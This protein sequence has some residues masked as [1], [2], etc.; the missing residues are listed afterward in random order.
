MK[1]KAAKKSVKKTTAQK[2]R[3]PAAQVKKSP[4]K[5]LMAPSILSADFSKL[6]AEVKEVEKAGAEWIHVD[7]MDGHFVPNLTLGPVIVKALRPRTRLVL[8]CHLMVK[9][10]ENWI[11]PF[12]TAGAD[13]ITIH[14]EACSDL[15]RA[16]GK[17][18]HLGK[19]AGV[20]INPATPLEVIESVLDQ[21][22]LVLIM[23]VNP[24]FGGQG[25]MESVL[26]KLTRLRKIKMDL[27]LR[28]PSNGAFLIEID[29]GISASNAEQVVRSG[30]DVLVAGSAI[31]GQKNR[32]K[33]LREIRSAGLL[34]TK[35]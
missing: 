20:S 14:A 32:A 22:D 10:P 30:A 11:E 27:C 4:S 7:V 34:G 5:I 2:K 13:Y 9:N 24:G 35:N 15:A 33:A 26:P 3:S 28:D 29:G 21:V 25:F 8:D 1:R 12:A 16:L 19:K 31:F 6:G 23:S 18:R 17:I